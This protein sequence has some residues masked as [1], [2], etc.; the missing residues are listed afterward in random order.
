MMKNAPKRML[1]L[2]L[3]L[4]LLLPAA[5]AEADQT[6]MGIYD[7]LLAE[8]S[9]Y[10]EM[11]TTYAE[12][13]PDA[14]F[15]ETLND[16]GF[17]LSIGNTEYMDGSWTFTR[18]GDYLTS[19]FAVDDMNGLTMTLYVVRAVSDC[20]GMT[21]ELINS[22]VNGLAALGIES[23][24]F[25][26]T[27]DEADGTSHVR[28][29]IAGPWDMKELDEMVFDERSLPYGSLNENS[30][31]LGGGI[32]KLMMVANGSA[33]DVTILLGEY[34][35]L[36]ELAYR[37]MIN[38]VKVLQPV[39]WE[40]FT[41]NYTELADAGAEG[42]SVRLNADKAAVGEIIGDARDSYSYAIMHFGK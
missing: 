34:G 30:I 31:S 2:L 18:D 26:M 22:Y 29:Y 17:T 13:F 32:G 15:E 8:G 12:Y 21:T 28:I 6:V 10:N 7:A 41:A 14:V 4:A 40:D 23:D 5:W 1:V 11:K 9:S 19:A 35:A 20:L 39:G 36:D 38:A 3:A 27:R 24:S 42:W 16:D 37:S 33:E 25:I